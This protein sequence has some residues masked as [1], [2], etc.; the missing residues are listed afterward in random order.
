ML[1]GLF[2]FLNNSDLAF[3][4]SDHSVGFFFGPNAFGFRL[5]VIFVLLKILAEPT[6]CVL[7]SVDF[8]ICMDFEIRFWDETANFSFAFGKNDKCWRLNSTGRGYIEATVPRS[9]SG[10]RSRPVESNQPVALASADGGIGQVIHLLARPHGVPRLDD[11]AISH[12]LHPHALDV[13]V[14]FDIRHLHQV[15][16]NQFS[17]STGIAS[18]HDGRDVLLFQQTDQQ[19]EPSFAALDWLQLELFRDV[20]QVFHA[21]RQLFSVL[22]GGHFQPHEVTNRRGNVGGLVFEIVLLFL[23]FPHFRQLAQNSRQIG[24][25]AWLFRDNERFG[26]KFEGLSRGF[27]RSGRFLNCRSLCL[28][29]R[30]IISEVYLNVYKRRAVFGSNFVRGFT[31]LLGRKSVNWS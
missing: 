3:A 24:G 9:K 17:F 4:T 18:V 31:A 30:K 2:A 19:L 10:Q 14:L 6:P 8:K 23:K 20:R 22:L 21:P 16:K 27:R 15:A 7:A 25:D 11:R 5:V 13:K 1:R 29:L 28:Q 26:H 12:R